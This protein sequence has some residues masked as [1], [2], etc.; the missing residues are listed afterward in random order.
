MLPLKEERKLPKTPLYPSLSQWIYSSYGGTSSCVCPLTVYLLNS[1]YPCS[2]R[3]WPS[4]VRMGNNAVHEIFERLCHQRRAAARHCSMSQS[5]LRHPG[6]KLHRKMDTFF[7]SV[8]HVHGPV[9]YHIYGHQCTEL[10]NVLHSTK[11]VLLKLEV[12]KNSHIS[13]GLAASNSTAPHRHPLDR[14][15]RTYTWSYICI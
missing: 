10:I 9:L 4:L 3:S 7:E 8:V 1:S 12:R 6:V 2:E 14:H 15:D 5:I 13:R 11:C